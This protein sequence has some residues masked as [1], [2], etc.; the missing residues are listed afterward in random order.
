MV[1][2]RGNGLH[3]NEQKIKF[4]CLWQNITLQPWL[5]VCGCFK[6]LSKILAVKMKKKKKQV[7]TEYEKENLQSQKQHFLKSGILFIIL[8]I[9]IH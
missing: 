2:T 3:E 1:V 9:Y 7:N 8:Y 6:F 4:E 5:K